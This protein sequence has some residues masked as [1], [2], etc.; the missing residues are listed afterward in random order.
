[1]RTTLGQANPYS[2]FKHTGPKTCGLPISMPRY[3]ADWHVYQTAI[4]A[5]ENFFT[6]DPATGLL[7]SFGS[8]IERCFTNK[9]DPPL[10]IYLQFICPYLNT[11]HRRSGVT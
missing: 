4:P 2:H 8:R 3:Q 1:M 5:A 6:R 10:L 11:R 9:H 7:L